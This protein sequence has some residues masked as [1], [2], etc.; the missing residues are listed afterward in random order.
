MICYFAASNYA[1]SADSCLVVAD[2]NCAIAIFEDQLSNSSNKSDSARW[3]LEIAQVEYTRG[4]FN[5]AYDQ[6]NQ[7]YRS[8]KGT[9]LEEFTAKSLAGMAHILWRYGDNIK[10]TSYIIESIEIFKRLE[11]SGEVIA[12]SN[13]L[14]GIYMSVGKLDEA[15]EI[16]QSMLK[17]AIRDADSVHMAQNYS[18]LGVNY[19]YRGDFETA[20][21]YYQKALD[22]NRLIENEKEEAIN[23]GNLGEVYNG[24][25]EP[26]KALE[27][28]NQSKAIM[29]RLEFNSGLI[30]VYYSMGESYAALGQ[31]ETSL[32]YYQKSIDLMDQVGEVREKA[33]VY[34]LIS[35]NYE[36][37][38]DLA[39]ALKF[40][41]LYTKAKDS[42]FDV[43]KNNQLEEIKA[44][45]DLDRKEQENEFLAIENERKAI[46]IDEKLSTIRL[47]YI[48]GT[49]LTVFVVIALYLLIRLSKQ[50]K[51]LKKSNEAKDKMFSVIAHDLRGSIGNIKS[52]SEL[53]APESPFELDEEEKRK[54]LNHTKEA[55]NSA[56][57]LLN[58]LLSWSISQRQG[59]NFKPSRVA[60]REA[61]D[62]TASLFSV[63]MNTK[64]IQFENQVPEDIA[65]YVDHDAITTILRNLLSNA[66]K[67]T[68]EGGQITIATEQ[69]QDLVKIQVK[70]TGEGISPEILDQIVNEGQIESQSGT[71]MEKGT[72][73]GLH[74]V[75][76]FVQ[77]A[78]G[79]IAFESKEG[80]G[81]T[82]IVTIPAYKQT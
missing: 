12:S 44:K 40:H 53:L 57:M 72:G 27:Y 79:N 37:K 70:D 64:Q 49:L 31:Y 45:Y 22:I 59:L 17:T 50:E 47:L 20:I 32:D 38:G 23:L 39:N 2:Y 36:R 62:H 5:L 41:Q 55:A 74:L 28:F 60:I 18:H 48:L 4:N 71:S 75:R 21:T 54:L 69:Q 80:E 81:T 46:E 35:R 8:C 16:Y 58:N 7:V 82:V 56:F 10:A 19:Y 52:F 77:N 25:S 14:A 73:M 43:T 66:I 6:Y 42:L 30:F 13:I 15:E 65:A 67:F 61:V 3:L 33:Y 63:Q 76:D 1:Q 11:M 34:Q 29:E 26:G 68:A 78:K 9:V 24:L 51:L